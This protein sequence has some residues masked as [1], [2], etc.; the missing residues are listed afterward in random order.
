MTEGG[1][2]RLRRKRGERR[3]FGDREGRGES[4][5]TE[6]YRE[7]EDRENIAEKGGNGQRKGRLREYSREGRGWTE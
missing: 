5:E 1:D 3:D 4:E 2:K 7:R 6:M